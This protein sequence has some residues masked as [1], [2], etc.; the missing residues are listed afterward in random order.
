MTSDLRAIDLHERYLLTATNSQQ[1]FAHNF[2]E[3]D[4]RTNTRLAVG[5]PG[6]Q[7]QQDTTRQSANGAQLSCLKPGL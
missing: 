3:I 4:Q 2:R 5:G 7:K 1:G 6:M